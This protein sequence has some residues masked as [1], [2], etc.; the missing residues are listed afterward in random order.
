MSTNVIVPVSILEKIIERLDNLDIYRCGYKFEN[1]HDNTLQKVMLNTQKVKLREICAQIICADYEDKRR[2]D[3][4]LKELIEYLPTVGDITEY[5][6]AE[7][8]EWI[9]SGHSVYDNPYMIYSDFGCPM[10]FIEGC[11]IG[12]DIRDN[13]TDYFSENPESANDDWDEEDL[14]F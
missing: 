5:E 3:P 6:K 7:L 9:V 8:H 10:D 2:N 11:R 12:D 13:P 4:L 14:P 1:E